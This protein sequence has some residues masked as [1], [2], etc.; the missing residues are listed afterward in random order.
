M[1][2]DEGLTAETG[3]LRARIAE[4]ERQ[5]AQHRPLDTLATQLADNIMLLDPD[6]TIRYI[7]WTVP[8]LTVDQVLGTKAY[9]HVPAEYRARMRECHEHVLAT[10]QPGHYETMYVAADGA[11]SRW[12]TRVRAIVQDGAVIGLGQVASNITE[13]SEGAH[14]RDRFFELSL[15]GFCVATADGNF[16]RVNP[17]FC[18]M[19]GCTEAD[20][21]GHSWAEFVHVAD[22][23]IARGAIEQLASGQ[24][25]SLQ[26]EV[27]LRHTDGS[28]RNLAWVATADAGG[29]TLIAV[30]RDVTEQRALE[31]R[32]FNTQ[33]LNALGELAAGVAHDFNNIIMAILGNADL[34]TSSDAAMPL[35]TRRHFDEI[36]SAALRA[37]SLTDRL[38]TVGQKRPLRVEV[39]DLAQVIAGI[40]DM[41][42]RLIPES[43]TIR[44]DNRSP[45]VPILADRAQLEHV[46]VNLC[47]NSRDAMPDGGLLTIETG[48]SDGPDAADDRAAATAATPAVRY[49]MLAVRDNGSGIA[50]EH[51]DR[52]FE[53]FFTTRETGH[54]LGLS[55][56]YGVVRQHHGRVVVES[57]PGVGTTMRLYFPAAE[58]DA[59]PDA[60]PDAVTRE[61][62]AAVSRRGT[63]R[64]L[65]VEDDVMVR[66]MVVKT[67]AHAGYDVE[68][69]ANGEE[70]TR[71]P[72]AVLSSIRLIVADVVM[73]GL[74]GPAMAL[75]LRDLG[76]DIP[77][78]FTSG[79][80]EAGLLAVNGVRPASVIQKP[81]EPAVLLTAIRQVLDARP[82]GPA[83]DPAAT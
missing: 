29:G 38:L 43:I 7:N 69:A 31:A 83:G 65:V 64:V 81:Y 32:L 30:A 17:S 45:A 28:Y 27:R 57:E 53:P 39:V 76:H 36:K 35:A 59:R 37:A 46:M 55:M 18:R 62:A 14:D 68:S 71:L 70:V 10:G 2:G 3:R 52:I 60:R 34:A 11:Q 9:E 47:I 56:V 19:L 54:G 78:I 72:A 41:L 1:S 77:V 12:E 23:S 22:A 21:V 61:P 58:A 48:A 67:L 50:P 66:K 44:V 74:S 40:T 13:R 25:A 63:E 51:R 16:K 20:L 42:E 24:V 73:P 49:A 79:Y 75:R 82:A 33:K 5:L 80:A 26:T 8:D 6:G 4:L 15:D